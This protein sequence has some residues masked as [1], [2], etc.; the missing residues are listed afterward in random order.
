MQ[1]LI[2]E[3]WEDEEDTLEDQ[4]LIFSLGERHYGIEIRNITEIVGVQSITEVPE[5]PQYIIGVMNLRGKIIPLVDAR[6]R[7]GLNKAEYTEK[8][9][10]VIFELEARIVGL[11]VDTVKEVINIPKDHLEDAPN[12][13]E[14]D[15]A[16]FVKSLAKV[17]GMVKI[18]LDLMALINDENLSKTLVKRGDGI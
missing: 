6:L 9:C 12:F 14:Q 17:K 2:D 13:Q 8:T 7:I 16:T 3:D 4:Y 1:T 15:K 11:I 10:V 5:M 18:I